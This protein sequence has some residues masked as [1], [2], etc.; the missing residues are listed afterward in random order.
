MSDYVNGDDLST[1]MADA[2]LNFVFPSQ[3]QLG[4]GYRHYARPAAD[5]NYAISHEG[6]L[7]VT[8]LWWSRLATSL[9]GS[10]LY[11]DFSH[12]LTRHEDLLQ[13]N[14]DLTYQFVHWLFL[15]GGYKLER[16]LFDNDIERNT[17]TRNIIL[18]H[19]QAQF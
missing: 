7:G 6:F 15:G 10:Y 5:T 18:V 11:S 8:H 1:W 2:E 3:T 13:A 19:L 16:L 14:A 17:T 9:Y 12:P 4:F